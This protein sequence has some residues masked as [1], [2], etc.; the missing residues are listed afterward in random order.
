MQTFIGTSGY[1]YVDWC[2]PFYPSALDK[3]KMLEYYAKEF[4]FTEINSSYYHLPSPRLFVQLSKKTPED[5]IFTVK[6]YKSLTHERE[7]SVKEDTKKFC[8]ALEP[9]L[10]AG[11]L[12]AV[13]LQFPYSFH[14]QEK[15]RHYLADL[16][17]IF[18]KAI[19]VVI[20]FRH[21]SWAKK[22]TWDFLRSLDLGYVCVDAPKL[23]GLVGQETVC[24]TE[25]AYVR[26]HGRN[27]A[28]WWEHKNS[29]ERYDYLYSEE[30]IREWAPKI[31]NLDKEAKQVFVAFNNHYR[32]QAVQNARMMRE[33]LK[34]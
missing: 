11:K 7:E 19:P 27:S 3:N 1:S 25:I 13:L 34:L 17:E 15:N 4:S 29:Y 24:T 26:F 2:G 21:Y 5:F 18:T 16:R 14:N 31:Q 6:A 12:G 23:R 22:A 30:E 28:K 9:L 33:M 20:E 8:F 10:V 32:G